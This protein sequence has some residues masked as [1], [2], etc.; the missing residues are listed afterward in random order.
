MLFAK[1]LLSMFA[2]PLGLVFLL[3]AFAWWRRRRWPVFAAAALLYVAGTGFA[4]DRL[5]GMLE[6]QS[7]PVPLAAL[8]PADAV[9]VLGGIFGPPMEEGY[10][11]NLGESV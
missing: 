3:L 1:K 11:P 10:L 5:L 7:A 6:T 2:L 8:Q 4:G 9:V